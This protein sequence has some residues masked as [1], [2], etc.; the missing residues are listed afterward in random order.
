MTPPSTPSSRR[1][2]TLQAW[3]DELRLHF[4]IEEEDLFPAVRASAVDAATPAL[5]DRLVAEHRRL[6]ELRD[7]VATSDPAAL[8]EALRAFAAL[9]EAHVR[10]EERQ[11]FAAFPGPLPA[12]EVERL[13]RTIH[14]RRPPDAPV[15]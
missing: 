10:L 14:A 15:A 1:L 13:H 11:L 9:L 5:V 6:A 2:E 12:A 4:A 7:R 8:D 3:D